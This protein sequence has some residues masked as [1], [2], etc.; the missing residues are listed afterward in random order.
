MLTTLIEGGGHVD[1]VDQSGWTP[2]HW[3]A[4]NGRRDVG[5]VLL[6]LG[7]S[8]TA[9][10]NVSHAPRSPPRARVYHRFCVTLI[11]VLNW[12]PKVL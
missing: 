9:T 8:I 7:A 2:L 12:R 4:T 6:D 10:T 3:A 1:R 5:L 11:C